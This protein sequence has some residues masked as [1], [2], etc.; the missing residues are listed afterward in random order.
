MSHFIFIDPAVLIRVSTRY[1]GHITF[2]TLSTNKM[3][4]LKACTLYLILHKRVHMGE[5]YGSSWIAEDSL[6]WHQWEVR[7][8]GLWRLNDPG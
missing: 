2:L 1:L 4:V 8:L 5:T 3:Q 6:S 7:S